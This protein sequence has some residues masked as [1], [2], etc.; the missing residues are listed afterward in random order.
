M[1]ADDP[2]TRDDIRRLTR[3]TAC[4]ALATIA[5]SRR[6]KE[7]LELVRDEVERLLDQIDL[8]EDIEEAFEEEREARASEKAGQDR[9]KRKR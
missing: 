3:M 7:G 2:A 8:Q 1:A 9:K 6:S 4:A 5:A